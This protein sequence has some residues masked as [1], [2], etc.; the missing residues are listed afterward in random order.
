[1]KKITLLALALLALMV[2]AYA[3]ER[4]HITGRQD[5]VQRDSYCG[6]NCGQWT[7]HNRVYTGTIDNRIFTLQESSVWHRPHADLEVG[8]DYEIVT[9][10][11]KTGQDM[12]IKEDPD[13]KGNV[14]TRKLFI[15]AVEEAQATK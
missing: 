1:M 13:Q 4:I 10:G 8:H 2:S 6:R 12:E 3:Q 5:S 14:H 7:H 11:S 15:V 9:Y